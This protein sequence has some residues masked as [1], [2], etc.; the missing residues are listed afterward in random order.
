MSHPT[1]TTPASPS[2]DLAAVQA[3]NAQHTQE[4]LD[5][6]RERLSGLG[7]FLPARIQDR[8]GMV[9][10]HDEADGYVTDEREYGVPMILALAQIERL[11]GPVVAL[12]PLRE[13]DISDASEGLPSLDQARSASRIHAPDTPATLGSAVIDGDDS[14][15]TMTF[16]KVDF[17]TT[18]GAVIVPV[19]LD[20]ND[21]P[22]GEEPIAYVEPTT[23]P[24]PAQREQLT[25]A[26]IEY[27]QRQDVRALGV[28][29]HHAYMAWEN[30]RNA[31]DAHVEVQRTKA[32]ADRTFSDHVLG[33]FDAAR[34]AWAKVTPAASAD[35][36]NS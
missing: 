22:H 36:N 5:N 30:L 28:R 1:D 14:G 9:W 16:P 3:E 24:S 10:E 15:A 8:R 11:H 35:P 34:T 26:A 4:L 21:S 6:A 25:R 7:A 31:C 20:P 27:A 32:E 13:Y 19:F 23:G 29:A 12:P 18:V 33:A 2:D 17:G